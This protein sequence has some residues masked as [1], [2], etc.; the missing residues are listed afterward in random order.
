MQIYVVP[1]G[2]TTVAIQADGAQGGSNM[3]G[4]VGG[5]GGTA[6]G[7]LTVTPGDTLFVYVGGSNGYNGGGLGGNTLN[8]TNADGGVGGGASDVRV[9][10]ITL[11]DRV[12]VGA[13]GGGAGG[14]RIN[15]CGRGSGGGGGGG[16]YGGG[17]GAG[18]PSATGGTLPTGGTQSAG[19]DKAVQE[20]QVI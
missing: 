20:V 15:G 12:I 16:Y 1:A 19:P 18:W 11:N 5:L 13:G 10:G 6:L 4:V 14:D 3:I 8:C 17:G 7:D 2:V 9:G